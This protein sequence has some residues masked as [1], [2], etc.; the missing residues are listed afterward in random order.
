[1]K[2]R[3]ALLVP[4]LAILL[5]AAGCGGD[6]ESG[7]APQ[8]QPELTKVTFVLAAP[9][10]VNLFPLSLA[11]ELGY[12]ADHGL[13][14]SIE[15]L[16][17]TSSVV[18]QVAAGNA[19][20]GYGSSEGTLLGFATYPDKIRAFYDVF[21]TATFHLYSRADSGIAGVEGLKGKTVGVEALGTGEAIF[22]RITLGNAGLDPDDVR[23]EPVGDVTAAEISALES[24]RVDAI[25]GPSDFKVAAEVKGIEISCLTC[26]LRMPASSTI[27]VNADFLAE[28]RDLAA[29]F[30]R[31]LAKATVFGETNPE[32]ALQIMER[33]APEEFTD[34]NFARAMIEQTLTEIRPGP[35]GLYGSVDPAAWETQLEYL[36]RPEAE[37]GLKE[38]LDLKLLLVADLAGPI[39]DF[40][41]G[42]I[43]AKAREGLK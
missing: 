8:A 33:V 18:K 41:I 26:G 16:D 31:A 37:V 43:R 9:A 17:G 4:V 5:L 42:A 3:P 36:L 29:A 1:M 13:D 7:E 27:M 2:H 23:L 6:S 25:A 35:D 39:N 19:E 10:K 21:N 22:A 28:H 30:G 32:A 20:F 14:V 15:S 38:R 40:D 24:G 12:F 34:P 11:K